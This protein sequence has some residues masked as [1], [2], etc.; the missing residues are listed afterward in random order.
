MAKAEIDQRA[1]NGLH[2]FKSLIKDGCEW[3]GDIL[4]TK[5]SECLTA[6][7]DD[8]LAKVKQTLEGYEDGLDYLLKDNAV[9]IY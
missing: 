2:L 8:V 4:S 9:Y 7:N 6:P 5:W 1:I 3:D